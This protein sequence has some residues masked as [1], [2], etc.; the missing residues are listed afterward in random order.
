MN[1]RFTSFAIYGLLSLVVILSSSCEEEEVGVY[2]PTELMIL[3][4]AD[5]TPGDTATYIT[6][7]FIDQTYS[8]TVPSGATITGGEGTSKVQVTFTA[9]GSGDITVTASDKDISGTKV[10]NVLTSEPVPTLEME[11]VKLSEGGTANLKI[12]FD[13][14]ISVAPI[15]TLIKS[16]DLSGGTLGELEKIDARTFQVPY[17]AGTGDGVDEITIEKAVTTEFFGTVTMDSVYTFKS[18]T[19]DNTSATGELSASKTPVSDEEIVIL[20]AVF[21]EALSQTDTIKISVTGI[22]SFSKYVNQANMETE[23]GIT[24]TYELQP[25]GGSNELTSVSL[26][27]VPSDIAG[28]TTE[29][30]EAIYLQIKNEE[31][32]EE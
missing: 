3:G 5:V 8:W 29:D 23:D 10:V 26:S 25:E 28:N 9:A 11:N 4:P 7:L 14:D 32:E 31:K 16:E 22:V 13:Q 30:V 20:S 1:S 18:Y 12:K 6:D 2:E 24:W 17:I 19:V 15:V 27:N 21:N